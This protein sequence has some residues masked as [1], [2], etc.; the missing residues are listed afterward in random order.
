MEQEGKIL[1]TV[2]ARKDPI[3]YYIVSALLG[4]INDYQQ[5]WKLRIS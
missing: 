5:M 2:S 4:N 3:N 1:S